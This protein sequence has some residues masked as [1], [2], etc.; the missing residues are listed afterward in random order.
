MS[1]DPI[2]F[3]W[4]L[5]PLLIAL[6]TGAMGG[7]VG[8]LLVLRRR[9]LHSNLIAHAVL[10]GVALALAAGINPLMGGMA[11]GFPSIAAVAGCVPRA[12]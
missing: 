8:P 5:L 3:A 10:P 12:K 9:V 11:C 6:L 2:T 7:V 1:P 4:W